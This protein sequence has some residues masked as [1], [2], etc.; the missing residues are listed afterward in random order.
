MCA[1][2]VGTRSK[3]GGAG[4]DA[5]PPTPRHKGP[6]AGPVPPLHCAA[7][8][9]C[10]SCIQPQRW[11]PFVYTTEQL[12][13][14]LRPAGAG[15][16]PGGPLGALGSCSWVALGPCH[17]RGRRLPAVLRHASCTPV[18]C[19][20]PALV[21]G[22]EAGAWGGGPGC[23]A[24]WCHQGPQWGTWRFQSALPL[25]LDHV[26]LLDNVWACVLCGQACLTHWLCMRGV[27]GVQAGSSVHTRCGA[28]CRSSLLCAWLRPA[29]LVC[30]GVG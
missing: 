29:A 5:S 2:G 9:S 10:C 26:L 4:R 17:R 18:A 3:S 19:A 15:E 7:A 6:S 20:L 30:T 12:A 14:V 23:T 27:G 11:C 1:A 22:S 21:F 13:T 16:P 8:P 25:L 28:T 24:P